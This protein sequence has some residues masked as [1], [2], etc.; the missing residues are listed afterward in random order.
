[1][2][3]T[4][5]VRRLR[6]RAHRL[7]LGEQTELVPL[8]ALEIRHRPSW[9]TDGRQASDEHDERPVVA[10]VLLKNRGETG[11]R[12]TLGVLE[13][14]EGDDEAGSLSHGDA[15]RRRERRFERVDRAGPGAL[16][17]DLDL[18]A[19]SEGGGAD[20]ATGDDR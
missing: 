8:P 20:A 4:R 18:G 5:L 7:V 2:G 15:H 13:L 10:H 16:Q 12:G 1:H 9:L 14:V 11:E 6:E 17:L 19:D 3:P